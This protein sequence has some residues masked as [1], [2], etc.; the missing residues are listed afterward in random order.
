MTRTGRGVPADV[1]ITSDGSRT[2][3]SRRYGQSYRSTRGA[4]S[5]A[6]A[7]FLEGSGVAGRLAAG[8]DCA[9]LEVGFGTGLNFLVTAVAAAAAADEAAAKSASKA[10]SDAAAPKL[11]YLALERELP[12]TAL[13]A[14]LDYAGLLTPS[15]LPAELLAW[16]Q[17]LE[18]RAATRGR[19]VFVPSSSPAVALELVLGEATSQELAPG[20]RSGAAPSSRA[21]PEAAVGDAGGFD[22]VYLDAFSPKANPEAW[23]PAFLGRLASSLAP[24]GRLVSFTVSGE[25]RRALAAHGLVVSKVAGP[26]GGKAEVLVARRPG[27]A[28]R[29]RAQP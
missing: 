8:E 28:E 23:Q 5:E 3:Y 7:V 20:A 1:L 18:Q 9:V 6:R 26:P 27:S 2:L 25:V 17:R 24:G 16:L 22:A 4:L 10:V 14:R 29:P 15:P 11:R 13:L 19:H 21:A 12:P